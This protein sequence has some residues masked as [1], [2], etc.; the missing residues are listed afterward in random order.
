MTR[1][2][3]VC[4]LSTIVAALA[5]NGNPTASAQGFLPQDVNDLPREKSALGLAQKSQA[6]N[7][8]RN[9][10]QFIPKIIGGSN[11]APGEFPHQVSLMFSSEFDTS[12]GLDRHFCGGSIIGDEWVL[13]AAHCVES[14]I[15]QQQFYSI[16]AGSIDLND[17]EEYR[18][19]GIWIHPKYDGATLDYDFAIVKVNRPLFDKEI[20]LVTRA[21]NH[22]IRVGNA[23]TITGWGVDASGTI[24]QILQKVDVKIVSRTDCNDADSY[25]G[26]VTS[27]MICLGLEVGGKDSCQGDSGGPAITAVQNGA[28][29]LFANVSWGFGCAEPEKFG[30]YGR[31]VA[32]RG[33]IDSVLP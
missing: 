9:K 15:G 5:M 2:K 17:L 23:A 21:D 6:I 1:F 4:L 12:P 13:T 33:W 10:R 20:Q 27:R 7:N 26:A 32:V 19:D 16:G 14:I 24:Q 8:L 31:L 28:Q 30:V 25:N 11:A 22:F 3:H 29:V 18:L